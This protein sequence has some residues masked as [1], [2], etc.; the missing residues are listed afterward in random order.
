MIEKRK[1]KQDE[2]AVTSVIIALL[3]FGLV[4][5]S[6]VTIQAVYVPRWVEQDEGIHMQEVA[7]SFAELKHSIDLQTI[8]QDK[9]PV[10]T[11][12][13]LGVEVHSFLTSTRS[14]GSLWILSDDVSISFS[15]DTDQQSYTLGIIKYKSTNN[16]FVNQQYILEAGGLIINQSQ[17]N[18]MSSDPS[19]VLNDGDF[20][21]AFTFVNISDLGGKIAI[22]G[23]GTYF[24]QTNYSDTSSQNMTDVD[25]IVVNTNYPNAWHIYLNNTF[26]DLG[27][28]YNSDF[29]ITVTGSSVTVNINTGIVVDISV[30]IVKIYTQI[31]PGLV[32]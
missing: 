21:I 27:Y 15:N 14:Y 23:Y 19:R 31:S 10:S 16:H 11:P 7:D 12:I 26:Q 1:M 8:S 18:I 30:D 32:R 20:E 22:S 28:N 17:G 2:Y 3:L 25:S 9:I 29:T 5:T 13:K 24:L 6:L 4:I